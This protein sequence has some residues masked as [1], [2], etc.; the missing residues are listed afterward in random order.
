MLG[1]LHQRLYKSR[2]WF[3]SMTATTERRF[4]APES[5]N[6]QPLTNLQS[7]IALSSSLGDIALVKNEGLFVFLRRVLDRYQ[8][9]SIFYIL[10]NHEA[11][12]MTLE[13]AIQKL[14]KFE[15]EAQSGYGGRF[16]F[17]HRDRYDI[18]ESVTILGCSL[19]SAIQPEQATDVYARLTDFNQ[20]RGIRDRTPRKMFAEH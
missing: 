4:C 5:W 7:Q 13:N 14:R 9:T 3:A 20:E 15:E 1:A 6:V 12:Q 16:R 18:R 8:G 17:L 2:T 19:W 11:Y 10:G